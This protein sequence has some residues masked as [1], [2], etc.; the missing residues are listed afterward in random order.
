VSRSGL[1]WDLRV[2]WVRGR[3]LT[4]P[5]T[6]TNRMMN[7]VIEQKQAMIGASAIGVRSSQVPCNDQ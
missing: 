5:G 1:W 7:A 3:A 2:V 6:L 4:I